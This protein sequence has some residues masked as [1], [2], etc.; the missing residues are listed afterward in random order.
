MN[1]ATGQPPAAKGPILEP[2]PDVRCGPWRLAGNKYR[3][4]TCGC[5]SHYADKKFHSCK[6]DEGAGDVG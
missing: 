6:R 1:E 4:G 5:L 3:C 2:E